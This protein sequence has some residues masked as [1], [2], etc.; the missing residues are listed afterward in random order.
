MFR[1][2]KNVVRVIKRYSA[3]LGDFQLTPAPLE[4]IV[5]QRRLERLDL[6]GNGALRKIERARRSGESAIARN[7]AEEPEVVKIERRHCS[8]ITNDIENNMYF[9]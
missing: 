5:T 9:F 4:Q 3:G 6:S 8:T 7:G 1:R 2:A